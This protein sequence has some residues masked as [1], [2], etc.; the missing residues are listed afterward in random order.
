MVWGK[1]GTGDLAQQAAT[2]RWCDCHA[3]NIKFVDRIESSDHGGCQTSDV[4]GQ[5]GGVETRATDRDG[6]SAYTHTI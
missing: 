2:S 6:R 3:K 4:S 5:L 1:N